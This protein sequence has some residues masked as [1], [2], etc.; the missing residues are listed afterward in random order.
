MK[1]IVIVLSGLRLWRCL[2]GAAG[3]KSPPGERPG[4]GPSWNRPYCP[5][6]DGLPAATTT[7]T[8]QLPHKVHALLALH[9]AAILRFMSKTK[10]DHGST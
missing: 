4:I 5:P 8:F 7:L 1:I 9:G 6:D 3:G 10:Q 2:V